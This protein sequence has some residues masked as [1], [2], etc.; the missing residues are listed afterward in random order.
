MDCCRGKR[1]TSI[2]DPDLVES[3]TYRGGAGEDG[4]TAAPQAASPPPNLLL[5]LCVATLV[6]PPS[7]VVPGTIFCAPTWGGYLWNLTVGHVG[8][9]RRKRVRYANLGQ[10]LLR[11][12]RAVRQCTPIKALN[13]KNLMS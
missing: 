9:S 12:R 6:A 8:S 1:R 10:V 7:I 2:D 3:G 11:G 5:R 4:P 13:I